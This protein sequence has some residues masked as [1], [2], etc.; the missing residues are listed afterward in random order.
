[1]LPVWFDVQLLQ[2]YIYIFSKSWS[3]AA[4]ADQTEIVAINMV[5]RWKHTCC[6][7]YKLVSKHDPERNLTV[8]YVTVA[9]SE[10]VASLRHF[11]Q[12]FEMPEVWFISA[13]I[14]LSISKGKISPANT[15]CLW[16]TNDALSVQRVLLQ[17]FSHIR[18]GE[19]QENR[20]R[21]DRE[22]A[23]GS[24][25]GKMKQ[26]EGRD[27][28]RMTISEVW[29]QLHVE[30]I[31]DRSHRFSAITYGLAG[32]SRQ[33]LSIPGNDVMV[34]TSWLE[35]GFRFLWNHKTIVQPLLTTVIT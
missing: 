35:L 8:N 4:C 31:T 22:R 6:Y 12:H 32:S 28:K 27:M 14:D 16:N 17:A 20:E 23:C 5:T 25:A 3:G 9:L 7:R 10:H 1:M 19:W 15:G 18:W 11:W 13:N 29:N 33:A 24:H 21:P 30:R 26:G 34:S 2:L